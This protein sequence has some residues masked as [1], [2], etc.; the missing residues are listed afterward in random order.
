M[1]GNYS[2]IERR[3]FEDNNGIRFVKINGGFVAL[4]WLLL[5]GRT[6]KVWF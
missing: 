4:T 5:H 1:T 6:V 2:H 3:V